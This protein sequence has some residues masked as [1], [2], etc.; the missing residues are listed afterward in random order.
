MAILNKVQRGQSISADLINN[1]IDSVRECQLQ[2]VVGGF[3]RRGPG[4][5]TITVPPSKGG[6]SAQI[7]PFTA[8]ATAVT[9]G[10]EVSFSI[11]TV[12]GI[13]PSNMFTKITGVTTAARTYFYIKATSDGKAVTSALIEKDTTIRTPPIPLKDV[14]P[15][16]VNILIAT[17]ATSGLIES[18]ISC[19]NLN[20]RIVPSIQEDNASYV[21]GERNLSQYYN[22]IF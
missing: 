3:F 15:A 18:T 1:I 21:T 20:A 8:I 16:E 14:A 11:G 19:D 10:F 5:T 2:S 12:N 17:M 6:G 4:G 9:T 13:L 7:C 22:W